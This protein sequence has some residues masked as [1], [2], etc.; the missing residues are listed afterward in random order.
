MQS[1][2]SSF[3]AV[4]SIV[5]KSQMQGEFDVPV[6]TLHDLGD[7]WVPLS[8]E[9]IYK[10]RATEKGTGHS[11]VQRVIR[12]VGH[13]KFTAAESAQA[14]EELAAWVDGGPTPAGDDVLSPDVLSA[15]TVGC[16]FT[17]NQT[18][19]EDHTQMSDRLRYQARYPAC[20]S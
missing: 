13:C 17:R 14:F 11:L 4:E 5:F 8:L 18:S 16:R 3:N 12:D 2:E 6:L 10:R 9:Q 19:R 1:D 15:P 20:P 7:I